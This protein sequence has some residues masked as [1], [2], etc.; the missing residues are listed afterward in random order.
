MS[1]LLLPYAIASW[2][3]KWY[4]GVSWRYNRQ[5]PNDIGNYDGPSGGLYGGG[6][7]AVPLSSCREVVPK[8][9]LPF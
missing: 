4:I 8:G 2:I 5:K 7:A 9:S 1:L 6:A 3:N